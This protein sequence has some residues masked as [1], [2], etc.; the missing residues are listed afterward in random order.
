MPPPLNGLLY[1]IFLMFSSLKASSNSFITIKSI[2]KLFKVPNSIS[3][4]L[5]FFAP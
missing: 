5:S 1:I 4:S 3:K 2:D